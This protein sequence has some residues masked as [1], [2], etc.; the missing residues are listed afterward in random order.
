MKSLALLF[1]LFIHPSEVVWTFKLIILYS[2]LQSKAPYYTVWSSG[3]YDGPQINLKWDSDYACL[4]YFIVIVMEDSQV[5]I[6]LGILIEKRPKHALEFDLEVLE[7]SYFENHWYRLLKTPF[8]VV[9]V[10]PLPNFFLRKCIYFLIFDIK[11]G[12]FIEIA[13]FYVTNTQA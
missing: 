5:Q 13:F 9:G 3:L 8:R 4:P 6:N 2:I 7:A 1:I 10:D 11:L 12:H